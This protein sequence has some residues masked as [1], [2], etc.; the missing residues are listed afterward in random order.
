MSK[1][2][3][4]KKHNKELSVQENLDNKHRDYCLCWQGC[5]HFK[6]GEK[7]NCPIAQALFE[8]DKKYGVTTPVWECETFSHGS[9]VTRSPE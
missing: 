4:R 5:I 3:K 7:D 8:F 2:I 9:F 6:P 1:I